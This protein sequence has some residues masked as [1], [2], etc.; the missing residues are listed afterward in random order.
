MRLRAQADQAGGEGET[1]GISADDRK[2]IQNEIDQV[3]RSNRISA[4]PGAFVVTPRK[5][6]FLFPLV[7]NLLAIAATIG[8]VLLLSF[9]FRQRDIA[10]A[11]SSSALDTAEGKLLQELKRDSDSKLQEKD[12]AITDFRTRLVS[13]DKERNDLA[14]NIDEKVKTKE[15]ELRTKFQA[16]LD[17]EKKRLADQ[18]LGAADLQAKIKAFEAEKTAALDKQLADARKGAEAEKAAAED[19]FNQLKS[20]YQKS[21]ASLGEERKLLQ[22]QAKKQEDALK[23][24]LEAKT[25]ELETQSAAA[26]A[27]LDKAKTDLAALEDQQTRAKAEDDRVIGLYGTIRAALRD[28]RYSDAASGA[29]ALVSYIKDPSLRVDSSIQ[30]RRDADLFVAETLGAYARSELDRASADASKLLAQADLL[31]SAR[32]ASA[33]AQAALKAGNATLASSKYL[34]ALGKVPE[35]LAA[36]QYFLDQLQAVEAARRA[37]LD[38]SLAAADRAFKAGDLGTSAARYSEALSYLPISDAARTALVSRLAQSGASDAGKGKVAA[39]T[40]AASALLASAASR[41]GAKDWS[42]AISGYIGLLSSFPA[43]EQ[44]PDALK[45]I[46][47][48]RAGFQQEAEAQAA[49]SSTQAEAAL[50]AARKDLAD[51]QATAKANE[52]SLRSEIASLNKQLADAQAK[53]AQTAA[54]ANPAIDAAAQAAQAGEIAQLRAEVLRLGEESAK[55]AAEAGRLKVGADKYEALA[56]SYRQFLDSEAAAAKKGGTAASLAAQSSLYAFLGEAGVAEAFPGLRDK[57]TAYQGASQ[58]ELLDS[59]PSDASEIVQ[60]ALGYKDKTALR[61]Y[62]AA[63]RDTY[64]KSSNLV[65]VNFLDAVSKVV[66]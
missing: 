32:E 28:R 6:G 23:A 39:D 13:L 21:L 14:A 15:T 55:N 49:S 37:K 42:G 8:A 64:Q 56:A 7:V 50:A 62:Y 5:K 24:S 10:I 16:E 26:K 60:Q 25:K 3:A 27:G 63:K 48:A 33:A 46:E 57:V 22:D 51:A 65:M 19:R 20:D 35:I 66:K 31:G 38:D 1:A 41:L 9:V 34:E 61:A 4:G 45:G 18:G 54:A 59:F 11:S 52:A 17:A 12:K 53:T 36:H 30:G 44:A 47:A 58:S 2:E 29:D 43:A 40:K